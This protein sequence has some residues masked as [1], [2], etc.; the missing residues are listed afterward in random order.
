MGLRARAFG[1][2]FV[3]TT[4]K[5]Q[6]FHQQCSQK[7]NNCAFWRCLFV[8]VGR[9]EMRS[10]WGRWLCARKAYR[11]AGPGQEENT[12]H[13]LASLTGL[14]EMRNSS[15]HAMY[16]GKVEYGY[17]RHYHLTPAFNLSP[18]FH[19]LDSNHGLMSKSVTDT[20]TSSLTIYYSKISHFLLL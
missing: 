12:N 14:M 9:Q 4:E 8:V 5:Q 17:T 3:W 18:S 10:C 13:L 20:L 7:Q 1:F 2:V 11:R 19:L 16:Q 15:I 6:Q